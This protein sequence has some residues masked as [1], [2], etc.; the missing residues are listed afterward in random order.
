MSEVELHLLADADFH[1][2]N[3]VQTLGMRQIKI[4]KPERALGIFSE[5][6]CTFFVTLKFV[7]SLK[8]K[9]TR[10][11]MF[12]VILLNIHKRLLKQRHVHIL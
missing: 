4:R 6:R 5:V 2:F 12:Y 7:K 10:F 8:T 1:T 11:E 3:S 9:F